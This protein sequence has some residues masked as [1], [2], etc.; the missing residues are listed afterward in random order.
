MTPP[1]HLFSRR[2]ILSFAASALAVGCGGGADGT[3]TSA[4]LPVTGGSGGTG[5]IGG[6]NTGASGGGNAGAPGTGGT[7]MLASGSIS[8]FGSVVVNN[9]RFDDALAVVNIDGVKAQSGDLRLGMVATVQGE[10][11]PLTTPTLSTVTAAARANQIDVWKTAQGPVSQIQAAGTGWQF[12]VAGLIVQTDAGTALE[13]F[14]APSAISPGQIVA[15]WALQED[16]TATRWRATRVAWVSSPLLVT[17]G[18]YRT[19]GDTGGVNGW[20]LKVNDNANLLSGLQNG[21]L[22]R[23]EGLPASLANQLQ[24]TGIVRNGLSDSL[25]IS[26]VELEGVVTSTP[27]GGR[28]VLSGVVV[29]VSALGS[30]ATQGISVGTRLEVKG[31]L[32]AGVLMAKELELEDD[33][34]L[35][36]VEIEARIEQ[37]T[38]LSN[39]VLRSQKCDA[40]AVNRIENGSVADLKVGVK[41]KVKGSKSGDILMVTQ[42]EIDD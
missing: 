11:T 4:S 32:S 28:F 26:D 42:L 20:T 10:R 22:V 31:S 12:S 7:G 6:G 29:D 8:G 9:I 18:L 30:N 15:V 16:A 38:S 13:G 39:F 1:I 2:T 24:V 14:P 27:F 17:T 25:S 41:I 21:Q 3:G 37:F 33:D 34:S 23:V 35:K 19:Q 40:S 5:N 36:L